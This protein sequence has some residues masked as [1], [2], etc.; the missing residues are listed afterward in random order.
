MSV[1]ISAMGQI[2][3]ARVAGID[4]GRVREELGSGLGGRHK[5]HLVPG[6][7]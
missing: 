7:L 4:H 3:E 6:I 5:G 2:V 1:K